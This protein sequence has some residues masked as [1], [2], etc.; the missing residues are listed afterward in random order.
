MTRK[1]L[2]DRRF[3]M[4]VGIEHTLTTEG[5]VR[6]E[7]TYGFEDGQVREIFTSTPKS[8]T[9]FE[10]LAMDASVLLSILLQHGY[11]IGDLPKRFGKPPSLIG[12]LVR[13]GARL[14]KEMMEAA[15]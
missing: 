7:V 13:A 11:A 8:G 9:D 5:R 4:T 2:P 12:T 14:E 3:C 15:E 6:F 1:R 10:H